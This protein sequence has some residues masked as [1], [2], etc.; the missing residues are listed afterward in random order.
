[1]AD[2]GFELI[3]TVLVLISIGLQIYWMIT[4]KQQTDETKANINK[5]ANIAKCK[6]CDVCNLKIFGSQ[7][8]KE[9][10]TAD[11]NCGAC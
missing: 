2:I 6:A 10:C 5:Y 11:M 9:L 4:I 1:M 3:I 8:L 7:P